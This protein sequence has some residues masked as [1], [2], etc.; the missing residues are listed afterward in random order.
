MKRTFLGMCVLL[1]ALAGTSQAQ[2]QLL[3]ARGALATKDTATALAALQEALK[4]GQRPA[5]TNYLLGMIWHS[6][7]KI[8]QAFPY[9]QASVKADD[10]NAEALALLGLTLVEKKDLAG[11]IGY[12][13]KAEKLGKKNPT[14]L[15]A[16]GK[17]FLAVDSVDAA[18]QRLLLAKEYDGT[19][20]AI[21]VMLGDAFLKQNVPPMA[22]SNYQEAVRINPKDTETRLKMAKVYEDQRNY[23][24]AV[25]EYDDL[26][27]LDSTNTA[28]MLA[29][30]KIL[31]RAK[32]YQRAIGPLQRFTHLLPK[33][34]EGS[35]YY[36]R[37]LAGTEYTAETAKEAERS[38]KLD[39]SNVE[40][41]RIWAEALVDL[42]NYPGALKAYGG[43][44]RR[45]ALESQDMA[46]YG[47]ALVGV[48]RE[49][50]ALQSLLAAVAADSTNCDPY[51]N[52]GTLYMKKQDWANAAAM[53]EKRITCDSRSLGA[54]LNAA[55][56]YMQPA[57]KN[58]VR[59]RE[60]LVKVV[61][62][63]PDFLLGRLWLGRYYS[64][65]DSLEQAKLQ[66]DE[67]L[68]QAAETPGKNVKEAGEANY[69]TGSYYFTMKQYSRS[70]ESFRK[71][72][73][74]SYDNAGMEL[75][76]GQ[77]QL[78]L[79]DPDKP[80][81]TNK[82]IV[83]EAIAHF[84]KAVALDPTSAAAHL[85]LAQ[86]LVLARE[87]GNNELNRKLVDEACGEYRKVLRIDSG[88]QDARKG[89]ERIG[90]A[91]GG[92]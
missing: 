91:G 72:Y 75:T 89:M 65:V 16:L 40:I 50:E 4:L 64:M 29:K 38:I 45:N 63:R 11:A 22:I 21:Y 14:V 2:D 25:R 58:L 15:V 39:S 46:K 51:Y 27:V 73:G 10:E 37:A 49:E 42:K 81:E 57:S 86:G 85:W 32:Q 8:D 20:P 52:L 90:C 13:K 66:Y 34:V 48:G 67:V 26:L 56:C 70:V 61:E 54:Y 53:F 83:D 24:E 59:A 9:L 18:I 87:E 82:S 19:N 12:L 44:K 71:A 23:N 6:R 76:W 84:R 69:M 47:N 80:R 43:L 55:L 68:K 92:K 35:Q 36:A 33:S 1:L 17:A 78:Q 7:G 30:G 88:N 74:M 28:A 5:E 62:T 79:L 41:W 3:K 60:L 77:A 31:V